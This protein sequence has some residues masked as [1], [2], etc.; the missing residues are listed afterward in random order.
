M[1]SV[2]DTRVYGIGKHKNEEGARGY[3]GMREKGE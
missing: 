1:E 2:L 3:M